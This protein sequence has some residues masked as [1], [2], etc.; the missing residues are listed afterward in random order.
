MRIDT[1]FLA[2]AG[3]CLIAGACLGIYMGVNEDF[4]LT[5]VHAH[6]NLAGW[7]SLALFGL[8]YRLHPR[9]AGR[10]MGLLHFWLAA[11]GALLL[12]PGIYLAQ[13]HETE[14]LAIVGS[15]LWLASALLFFLMILRLAVRDLRPPPAQAVEDA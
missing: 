10:R 3:A 7:A 6:V 1:A 4:Q 11:P 8:A 13:I 2:V 5:A 12:P 14:L 9:L 15:L